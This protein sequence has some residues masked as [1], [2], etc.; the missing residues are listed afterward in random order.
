MREN[1]DTAVGL[2]MPVWYDAGREVEDGLWRSVTHYGAVRSDA[3]AAW[4]EAR[5]MCDAIGGIG[6]T[7]CPIEPLEVRHA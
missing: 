1:H 7:V 4:A 2:W 6:F 5:R 3:G